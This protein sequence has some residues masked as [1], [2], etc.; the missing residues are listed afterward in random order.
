MLIEEYR[1]ICSDCDS[2]LS[3]YGLDDPEVVAIS[4]LHVLTGHF[5]TILNY[6]SSRANKLFLLFKFF[7]E[8]LYRICC[9]LLE[10]PR[11]LRPYYDLDPKVVI[12]S[13]LLNAG[14][15]NVDTDFYYGDLSKALTSVG[16]SNIF[17][18]LNHTGIH[19]SQ[20]WSN[21][22]ASVSSRLPIVKY[23]N[24]LDEIS[25]A[26]SQW[27]L[28][29]RLLLSRNSSKSRIS[30]LPF[31]ALSKRTNVNL[32]FYRQ[33]LFL[34][35]KFNPSSVIV[36]YEGHA[37]ERLAFYAARK[38]NPFVSCIAYQHAVIFPMQHSIKRSLGSK[39]DPD[40]IL[41][42]GN[43]ARQWFIKQAD[44]KPSLSVVGTPRHD[45]IVPSAY[46]SIK[47]L[48]S[49]S[50]CL[51]LPDGTLSESLAIF[52]FGLLCARQIENIK[53]VIRLHPVLSTNALYSADP[54]LRD[55]P[56]NFFVSENPIEIDFLENRWAIYRGSG[57][58][59]RAAITGLR[60]IYYNNLSV[61]M[62]ID[63]LHMLSSWRFL[64]NT[65]DDV[66]AILH[67]DLSAL[68][69]SIDAEYISARD[70]LNSLFCSF[71]INEFLRRV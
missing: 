64:A 11:F 41:F 7:I 28:F 4:H 15:L 21:P 13:H 65:V 54:S 8:I 35:R 69:A 5:S 53:F 24:P 67:A 14:Q 9:S 23:L 39:F 59:V 49:I 19:P 33:A 57:A 32:R 10:A 29:L 30:N 12:F 51:L 36:T 60:P 42:S 62:S 44:Y 48:S 50:S 45:G 52:R 66:A 18:L 1:R 25:I 46:P 68:P 47:L 3:S 2:I 63:P 38:A 37:W 16:K 56:P 58:G 71:K 20:L 40:V 17:V 61:E 31:E 43:Y 55:I 6:K 27:R 70:E 26:W 34:L 22:N